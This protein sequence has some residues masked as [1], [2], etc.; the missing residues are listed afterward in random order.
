MSLATV[1]AARVIAD[2]IYDIE[3]ARE[4]F[5]RRLV[6]SLNGSSAATEASALLSTL[7]AYRPGPTPVYIRC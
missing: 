2:A 6:V 4:Q 7:K 3:K 5:A 1:T